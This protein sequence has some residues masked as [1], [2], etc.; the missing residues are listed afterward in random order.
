MQL[1]KETTLFLKT[2]CVCERI[3]IELYKERKV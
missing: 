2:V 3:L 1:L